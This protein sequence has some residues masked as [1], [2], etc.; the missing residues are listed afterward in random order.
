M[1]LSQD[2]KYMK[3]VGPMRAALLAAEDIRSVGDLVTTYPYRYVDR[4]RTYMIRELRGDM[5]Y[6]QVRGRIQYFS[7]EGAG[8]KKRLTASFTDGAG[9]MEL[10]WFR[11]IQSV[12]KRYKVGVEYVAFGVPQLFGG[13]WSIAHP[14]LDEPQAPAV[15]A[16]FAPLY[17]TSE[18]MKRAGVTSKFIENLVRS[19]LSD[20]G[21][22]IPE[23]LPPYILR[24]R[25]LCSR[26]K[27]LH[28]VHAPAS[29]DD[30]QAARRR[31]KFEE[32]FYI[33][34]A[35]L[36]Y[37]DKRQSHSAGQRFT[38][39]GESFLSFYQFHLPFALTGAQKRVTHEIY[40]DMRSGRQMNR[41]LQGDVGSGKTVVALMAMLIAID[42]NKQVCLMA[43]TEILAE[44]HY[45]TIRSMLDGMPLRVD[46]L[47]SSVKGRRRQDTLDAL[48]AGEV[49]ILI[50]THAVI[51]DGV[52]FAQ[53]GLAVIDEQH[54]FGV[55]QRAALWTKSPA[56]PHVLVM[57]ATPIPRTLAMTVYGDLSVS[58]LDELPPGRKPVL[59]KLIAG[60]H[61]D[62][63]FNLLSSEIGKGHQAYYV[64]PLIKENEKMDLRDLENGYE[65]LCEVFPKL[66]IAYVHGKLR[67]DA[68]NEVMARFAAGEVDI[69]V[70]TTVIE[71][72]VNVPNATVM[73]VEGA[74][75]FG[76]SQL[77]QLRGRVGRNADQA[78]CI[79]VAPDNISGDTRKRMDIMTATNDGFRIA[80]ED[81]R[82]RGPGD[83]Q[84]T[85]QSGIPF[86]L[87]IASLATD[88]AMLEEARRLAHE[89]ISADP[90]R[91]HSY[92]DILWRELRSR[93]GVSDI[94]WEEIS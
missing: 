11:S 60:S 90:G 26:A 52:V 77:H 53:L 20:L 31:L 49:N 81:L 67:P 40:D 71:V 43:P 92:N 70:A 1:L 17:H 61:H 41:L 74:Q 2:I 54:R 73:V 28:D 29:L 9:V 59:T 35:L 24:S 18:R 65:M 44:Q 48:A 32:L 85:M 94:K 62:E 3:G 19:A 14:E 42:N 57:T 78:Y 15:Q 66:R 82:L 45:D 23:T 46:L 30:L 36:D 13:H 56:P 79:L 34:L 84:G 8:R 75:R 33:Q 22:N 64:Y 93:R 47:T 83:L 58:V 21:E 51:E 55:A 5:P 89:V 69:L 27:A 38:K 88:G 10:V 37:A 63:L 12:E 25:G 7:V 68:K 72:G 6:V 87:K 76:L 80:E 86:N 50:G 4:S 39:I 16:A 91:N